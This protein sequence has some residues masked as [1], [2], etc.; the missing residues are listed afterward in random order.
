[1][2]KRILIGLVALLV[3]GA[4][5]GLLLPRHV[6]VERSVLIDRP[7]SL[8]FATLNSFQLF[9]R[10]SPWQDLDPNMHQ[11]TQGPRDGVGAKLVWSGN[12]KV[13]NG[14]QTITAVDPGR[15]VDTD[16][17]FGQMGTAK[18]VMT[19]V[20]QG[21]STKVTWSVVVDMGANPIG[22][23]F[24][25][26]MDGMLG[27]DFANGLSKLKPL[28]ESMPNADIAGF[29]AEEVQL[30]AKPLL[31]VTETVA[32]NSAAI[33][34]AYADG[35]G[36]IGKVMSKNKFI[37]AGAPLGIDREA[38]ASS[39]SFDAG[40]PIAAAAG[41]GLPN[42]T[43]ANSDGVKLAQSASGKALKTTHVGDYAKLPASY[44]KLRAFMA[45]H[46]YQ[47][48]GAPSYWF[49]DDPGNTPQEKV[50]TEIYVPIS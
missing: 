13:G 7:P 22:H 1:M 50:R 31:L 28:M 17:D 42:E 34:Q 6:K 38:S 33:G 14:T 5:V 11:T 25:L 16:L 27:K 4:V 39:Y 15:V 46:G 19:L 45:A 37:P 29:T 2:L 48:E 32:P 26:M 49:V 43:P 10:W 9:P 44:D 21:T 47:A 30:E 18:S 24:G 20:P 41:G 8:I 3:I 12:D 36:K 23:Y 35:F 40:I